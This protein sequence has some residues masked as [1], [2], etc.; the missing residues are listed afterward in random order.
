MSHRKL[1]RASA[2]RKALFRSLLSALFTHERIETT[3]TRAKEL[4]KFADKV[5]TLA[6]AGDLSSRRRAIVM[7]GDKNAVHKIFEEASTKFASR[8]SG[9]TRIYKLNP[10]R[11]DA[12]PMALIELVKDEV[13]SQESKVEENSKSE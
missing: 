12:A 7:V 6:K 2:P 4:R 8:N 5:V 3:E 11:G 9:Y 1:G 13:K 10:R